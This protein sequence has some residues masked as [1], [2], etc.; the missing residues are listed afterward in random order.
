[1]PRAPLGALTIN[2]RTHPSHHNL[3][4][5]LSHFFRVV[6]RIVLL[7]AC[8]AVTAAANP[9][10]TCAGGCDDPT[11]CRYGCGCQHKT[12]ASAHCHR[13]KTMHWSGSISSPYGRYECNHQKCG[14]GEGV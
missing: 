12:G 7:L 3:T 2:P 4:H 11:Q 6:R 9:K 8:V 10:G 13:Y 1:M 14:K 5:H